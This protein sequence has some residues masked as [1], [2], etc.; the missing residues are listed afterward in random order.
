MFSDVVFLL[1]KDVIDEN[2]KDDGVYLRYHTQVRQLSTRK[3]LTYNHAVWVTPVSSIREYFGI[4]GGGFIVDEV[5]RVSASSTDLDFLH[6]FVYEFSKTVGGW[7]ISWNYSDTPVGTIQYPTDF[8]RSIRPSLAVVGIK[9]TNPEVINFYGIQKGDYVEL[10]LEDGKVR[11]GFF[12]NVYEEQDGLWAYFYMD[13]VYYI[14]PRWAKDF[15][16]T[17]TMKNVYMFEGDLEARPV[18]LGDVLPR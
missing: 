11:R 4:G 16:L 13:K 1:A 6:R 18:I 12:W 17:N 2:F 10:Q 5:V 9:L 7:T 3:K 14:L 8:E 15:N